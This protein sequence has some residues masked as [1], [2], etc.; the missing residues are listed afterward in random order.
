MLNLVLFGGP[1]SGKGT[2]SEKIKDT[3]GLFHISTGEVLRD[4]ISRNTEIGKTANEYISKGQL[5]PDSL[6][7]EIVADLL[8]SKPEETSRGVIFDGFPRT[9]AQAEA[10]D[11]L[12]RKRNSKIDAVIGLE[13]PDEVL[14]ERLLKRGQDTGRAD[15]NMETIEKRLH[16]Y[17]N[18]TKPLKAYYQQSDRYAKI[19]G[20]KTIEDIFKQI[21]EVLNNI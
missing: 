7:L 15:D 19:N 11:Q 3:Y 20:E 9:L 6:M 8:D 12:L 2:Q 16:V 13:V 4:H 14:I 10:L 1:G 17:H 5:I 18:Q 21:S